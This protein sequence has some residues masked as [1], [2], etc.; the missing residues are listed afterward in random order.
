MRTPV[1]FGRSALGKNTLDD[2]APKNFLKSASD[3][4]VLFRY[5]FFRCHSGSKEVVVRGKVVYGYTA[6]HERVTRI[7][8]DTNQPKF[9]RVPHNP[10]RVSRLNAVTKS[11]CV[12]QYDYTF[13]LFFPSQ[14]RRLSTTGEDSVDKDW[15][16]A[17]HRSDFAMLTALTLH[18]KTLVRL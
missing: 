15:C 14:N 6:K 17:V 13:P 9:C 5:L 2:I 4:V 12:R 1:G 3:Q 18:S 16:V 11:N 10:D 7:T 8:L